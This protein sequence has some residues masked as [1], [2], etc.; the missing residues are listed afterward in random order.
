MKKYHLISN[1]REG[2]SLKRTAHFSLVISRQIQS[3]KEMKRAYLK[4]HRKNNTMSTLLWKKDIMHINILAVITSPAVAL[5]K[6][7]LK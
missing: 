1:I 5:Q 7:S 3:Q 2:I 6:L 4:K